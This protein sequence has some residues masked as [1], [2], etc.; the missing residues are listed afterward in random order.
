MRPINAFAKAGADLANR[1]TRRARRA[2][3]PLNEIEG[4]RQ[5]IRQIAGRL[6]YRD[7]TQESDE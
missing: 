6:P 7:V 4:A 1:G 5:I 3:R 2:I